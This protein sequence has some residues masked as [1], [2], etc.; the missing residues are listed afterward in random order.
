[1]EVCH[2]SINSV[3]LVTR[4]HLGGKPMKIITDSAADITAQQAEN[5]KIEIVPIRIQFGTRECPMDTEED[6]DDFFR[7]LQQS[8]ELPKTSQPSPQEYLRLFSEAQQ[9]DEEVLVIT[10]SSGLSGIINAAQLARSIS[11]YEKIWILDSEQAITT[12]RYLV[13]RAAALRDA[14]YADLS[15]NGRQDSG[16]PGFFRQYAAYQ[17]GDRTKR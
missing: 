4:S 10:L 5:M 1:P 14:G 16:G 13:E 2:L 6:F 3:Y 9:A 11:G 7:Q 17:A 12:Q 8:R 15:E